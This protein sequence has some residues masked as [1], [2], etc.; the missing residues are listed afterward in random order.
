M[1][2]Y[3]SED[4]DRILG[5]GDQFME[6]WELDDKNDPECI[7][8][9]Q[10]WDDIRPMLVAA[11][12]LLKSLSDLLGD[13]PDIQGGICQHCGRDYIEEALDGNCPSD[14][15]PAHNARAVIANLEAQQ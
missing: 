12:A 9:H 6:D 5:I 2:N 7:E 15:C 13:K 11:P 14:D 10:E 1:K 3:T 4:I 8:P